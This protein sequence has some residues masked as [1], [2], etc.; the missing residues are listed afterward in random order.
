MSNDSLNDFLTNRRIQ[1]AQARQVA[2]QNIASLRKEQ[3][4]NNQLAN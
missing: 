3:E 2:A 1:M 4:Y